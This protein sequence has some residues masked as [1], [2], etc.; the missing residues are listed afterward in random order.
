MPTYPAWRGFPGGSLV[1]NLPVT[2]EMCVPSLGGEGLL[3]EGVATHSSILA[4]EIPWT[5]EPSGLQSIGLQK[6]LDMTEQAWVQT[7]ALKSNLTLN[8]CEALGKWLNL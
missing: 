8:S 1:K 2:Q 5:E 3:E 7:L 6:E 4:W